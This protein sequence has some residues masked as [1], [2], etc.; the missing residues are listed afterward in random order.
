VLAN[1][2]EP[3]IKSVGVAFTPLQAEASIVPKN[4]APFDV[5]V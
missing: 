3:L 1:P 5:K 4:D 2:L